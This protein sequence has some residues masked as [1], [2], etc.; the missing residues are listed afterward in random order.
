[1]TLIYILIS[2]FIFLYNSPLVFG[3]DTYFFHS[4]DNILP[5]NVD[6]QEEPKKIQ[7]TP[8]Q[9]TLLTFSVSSLFIDYGILT[10][11]NPTNRSISL[12]V[13]AQEAGVTIL[14]YQDSPLHANNSIIPN[15][16]CDNGM[17]KPNQPDYWNNILTYGFGYRC[18]NSFSCN[19]DFL[20]QAFFKPYPT[21]ITQQPSILLQSLREMV[22]K[23]ISITNRI[24]ISGTQ[25]KGAYENQLY[26]IAVPNL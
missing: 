12:S 24:N 18:D 1:M 3:N 6:K 15:T 9:N 19:K 26:Y 23:D 8:T 22:L 20:Q 5:N 11:T 17:C 7:I 21:Y 25:P 16:T 4:S 2:F 14:T 10:P 13:E